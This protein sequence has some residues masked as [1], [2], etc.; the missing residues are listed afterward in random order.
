MIDAKAQEV[1]AANQSPAGSLHV[2]PTVSNQHD[3]GHVKGERSIVPLYAGQETAPDSGLQEEEEEEEA[4]AAA[5]QDCDSEVLEALEDE[6]D[7]ESEDE[8]DLDRLV[9]EAEISYPPAR[10]KAL[11]RELKQG[12][13]VAFLRQNISDT[14]P[15]LHFLVTLGV[16]LPKSLRDPGVDRDV[17][18]SLLKIALHRLLQ[19]REKLPQYNTLEDALSLLRDSRSTIV[20]SGAGISTSCGIPDFRSQDGIY[21]RLQRAGEYQLDDPQDMFDKDVFLYRPHVFYSFAKDIYPS[22]FRPSSSHRFIR[23]LED[24]GQLLRNYTQNIDTLEQAAGIRKVL[25]CH[26]S[27]ATASCVT[28]SF[29]APGA[30]IKDDIFAQRVPNCPACL[31]RRQESKGKSKKRRKLEGGKASQRRSDFGAGD[32]D[33][34]DDEND[35]GKHTSIMKPD[36]TFFGEK[37]SSTFEHCLL[38]DRGQASLLV[39]IGTSLKVAPVS[40]VVGHLPH[41]VPVI[42]INKTPVLH[43]GVDIMLLGDADGIVE[44]LCRKLGWKLPTPQPD[45][46]VVG[47]DSVAEAVGKSEGD[48]SEVESSEPDWEPKRFRDT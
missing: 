42:L 4:A 34:D 7:L 37:L 35:D 40:S 38:S 28:C 29:Q 47:E 1:N 3:P 11:V 18:L 12:G 2:A 26:G 5:Y 22:N 25:N 27:F 39:I 13:L 36:I 20:L 21:A 33:A 15:I 8:E 17:L 14:T 46:A 32:S 16:L 48:E 45:K 30:T 44:W 6:A 41:S 9:R 31:Q 24:R 19:R 23:L 10:V 43:V